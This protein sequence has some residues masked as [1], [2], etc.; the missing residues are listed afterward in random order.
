M[1]EPTKKDYARARIR[2]LGD[3][4]KETD[5]M[6]EYVENYYN[7]FAQGRAEMRVEIMAYLREHGDVDAALAIER[8]G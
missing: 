4:A 7:G 3:E 1:I 6:P 8:D 2:A 5:E